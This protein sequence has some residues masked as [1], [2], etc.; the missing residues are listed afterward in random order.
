MAAYKLTIRDGPRVAHERLTTLDEA[1]DALE[2]HGT[3]LALSTECETVDLRVRSFEPADQV[4][5]RLALS[6]P[7]RLLP[8]VRAG[9]DVRGDG[10]AEA[11]IGG[12]RRRP[13]EPQDG[14]SPYAALRRVLI[15]AA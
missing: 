3:E 1:L 10:S 15:D 2:R 14:E 8:S 12:A 9:I 4:A 11:W 13:V 7:E 5:A 6:G